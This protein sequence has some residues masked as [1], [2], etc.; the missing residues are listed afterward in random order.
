MKAFTFTLEAVRTLR[1]RQEKNALEQYSKAVQT[2]EQ[3]VALLW[4]SREAMER[5]FQERRTHAEGSA[6]AS[7]VQLEGW[8]VEV[9]AREKQ[10]LETVQIASLRVEA[11]WK[12]LILA[13]QEREIVDKYFN[14]QRERYDRTLDCEEQKLLDELAGGHRVVNAL[15][16]AVAWN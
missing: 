11:T 5:I 1:I 12:N 6:A 14:Q 9:T 15:T 8:T 3:A 10:C 13:R 4:K 7:L 2:R 16:L